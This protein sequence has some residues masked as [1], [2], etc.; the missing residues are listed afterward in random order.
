MWGKHFNLQSGKFASF[1]HAFVF[2]QFFH[3]QVTNWMYNDPASNC[4]FKVSN[5]NTRARCEICFKVTIKKPNLTI[6]LTTKA[7]MISLFLLTLNI[8]H[9]MWKSF[10]CWFW[11]V[12]CWLELL[13]V[14]LMHG[15]C[16]K[17]FWLSLH[18]YRETR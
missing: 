8:F 6:K 14:V 17:Y 3:K 15:A 2:C 12:N 18:L 11:T 13:F 1:L 7:P 16:W 5:R 10:Y 9:F 4:L